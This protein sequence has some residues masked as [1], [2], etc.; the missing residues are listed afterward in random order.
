MD[1]LQ[2]R[3]LNVLFVAFICFG[4]AFTLIDP[5]IPVISARLNIGYDKIGLI[6]FASST[7]S[8]GATFLSGRFSDR[9]DMKK[10][11]ATGLAILVIGFFIYG[12][13]F[14]LVTF[15]LTVIFFKI[16]C[17]ILDSSIHAFVSK[18]FSGKH[19]PIFI[20]LDFFWY[21]GAIL[22]PLLVSLFLFLKV[23]PSWLFLGFSAVSLI[24]LIYFFTK[25]P[26]NC[27]YGKEKKPEDIS[28]RIQYLRII[29]NPV[30][31]L[32]CIGLFFYVGIF[33]ILS[34]WLTTYF[35]DL[36]IAVSLGSVI[37]SVFWAFNALGVVLTGW[38]LK[39]SNEV[40]LLIIFGSI[41]CISAIAYGLI[42]SIYIKIVF[43]VL[44]AIFY[45]SFFPML[46]AIAVHEDTDLSG[47]ILGVTIST[48]VI[49][50]IVFQPLTGVIVEY[51]GPTGINYLLMVAAILAFI[52]SVFLYRSVTLKHKTG[53]RFFDHSVKR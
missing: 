49:G 34:T 2:K 11:I 22:G 19:G 16:G 12:I 33:S 50:L 10:I 37:L 1:R 5:L 41:G 32:C 21:I 8:L 26:K 18:A 31:V 36:N 20:K 46:N 29:R 51:F 43:L 9:Y 13:F 47:T 35:S 52:S 28:G 7:I 45:S 15:I 48:A 24:V 14:A 30:I 25:C 44:Q 40:S 42:P 27:F 39:R 38:L 3:T 23:D 53:F 4:I 6:L 17:G